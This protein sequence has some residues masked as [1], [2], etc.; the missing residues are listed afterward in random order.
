MITSDLPVKMYCPF[1]NIHENVYF[2]PVQS[3]G[4][5]FIDIDSFNG[6]NNNWHKC[7]E[8]EDCKKKAYTKVFSQE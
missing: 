4:K 8:C 5:W 7:R 2:L 6:C 3:G 1:S